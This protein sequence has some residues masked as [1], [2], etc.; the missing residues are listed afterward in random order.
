MHAPSS[1]DTVT[2]Q[3]QGKSYRIFRTSSGTWAVRVRHSVLNPN[4][5]IKRLSTSIQAVALKNAKLYLEH[6]LSNDWAALDTLKGR[7]SAPT[8]GEIIEE[9]RRAVSELELQSITVRGSINA[10][11]PVVSIARHC[12]KE[13]ARE[14]SIT[15][16]NSDLIAAYWKIT[17]TEK[18]NTTASRLNQA[19]AVFS[20]RAM[21][22]YKRKWRLPNLT[23]FSS[24]PKLRKRL[25]DQTFKDFGVEVA[26]Q[27]EWAAQQ[28]RH[29]DPDTYRV[30]LFAARLGLR[31]NEIVH[32]RGDWIEERRGKWV[33]A[34]IDRPQQPFRTKAGVHRWL[35]LSQELIDEFCEDI[36]KPHYL[37]ADGKPPTARQNAV[38]RTASAFVRQH[39]PGRSKSLHE[40]RKY[41]GARVSTDHGLYAAK[42]FLGHATIT[43]TEKHYAAYLKTVCA[44]SAVPVIA[45]NTSIA[46]A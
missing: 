11:L 13:K 24:A 9:Y 20:T 46:R 40:L 43:T 3:F 45:P 41:A 34:I 8:V 39:L 10:L 14:T 30:Y 25:V 16:L 6:L 21:E 2:F 26:G 38:Y 28:I 37:V 35:E 32:A 31:D 33:L 42:E 1:K 4:A 29:T 36:G 27:L 17:A 44:I 15:L 19:Q 12:D 7:S 18:R 22:I 23:E 5:A